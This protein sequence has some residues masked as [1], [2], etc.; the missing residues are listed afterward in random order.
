MHTF[1]G[2]PEIY[3]EHL[4]QGIGPIIRIGTP[5]SDISLSKLP[6]PRGIKDAAIHNAEAD[7]EEQ[8]E[9]I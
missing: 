2:A 1:E 5:I 6:S 8:E 9:V 3:S 7:N 4:S